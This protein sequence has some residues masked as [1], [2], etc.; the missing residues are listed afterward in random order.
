MKRV[1][2]LVVFLLTLFGYAFGQGGRV[3]GTVTDQENVP[4]P[5]VNIIVEGSATGTISD[6]DGTYAID[7]NPGDLLVF[8]FVGFETQEIRVGNSSVIDIRLGE[9]ISQLDEVVVTALGFKEQ[10]DRLSSTYSVI[11]G[12]DVV[13]QGEYKIIDGIGGKA[14]GV[15]VSS[16]SGD[17]GA[18]A[19]IQIRGQNTITG[20]NQP[21]IIVDG[22][23]INNDW[24]RGDGSESDAGVTQQSRLNDLNPDDIESF[25]VYKGASA[26]ALYGTRA[27]NGVIVITTKR[28]SE[29]RL[30]ATFSSSISVDDVSVRHPLQTTFGQG[31]GGNYSPTDALSWGDRIADRPGG[32]DG[33][34]TTG[35]YFQSETGNLIYPITAKNSRDVFVD[36]NF[37]QVFQNG[38]TFDNNL[39]LSGGSN[40]GT[41]FLS[42]GRINQN[43]IIKESYYDKTNLTLAA[44]QNLTDRLHADVKVNYI[45]SS[46]N[47]T[48]QSSNTA[49]LYLALLRTPPDFDITDYIGDY[50]SSSGAVTQSRQRSYRRY[51][52]NS[53]NATYNNP[54]WTIYQQTNT[55]DVD[56]FIGSAQLSYEVSQHFN[57]LLRTG[58]DSY[59]DNRIYFFPYYT[60]GADRRYGLLRDEVFVNKE[61]NADLLGNLNLDL[62]DRL[63]SNIVLGFGLNDRN[64]KRNFSQADN[65]I[66]NF[67][68][69]L[70][71]IEVS[72]KENIT[73][74]VGR[75]LRRNIR[76]YGTASFDY[77]NQV[78]LTLGGAFEKHSTLADPF[79]YPS[80]ELGWNFTSSFNKP[81]WFNFGKL[82]LS[83]GQVGNVPLPHRAQT[84]YEVGSFSTFSDNITLE[85]FGGGYQLDERVGNS[86]LQPEIKTE[87]EAGV[88][89]RFFR[90]RISL[91]ATY[92]TNEIE[93]AL[94]DMA[95]VPSL[96]FS[97]I[98]GNGATIENN[99]LE[100]DLRYDFLRMGDW[101]AGILANFSRNRNLVTHVEGGGVINFAPGS[102][103]QSVAIEGH[104][105]GVF[106]T[107]AAAR[108][109]DGSLLLDDN[110]FPQVDLTG[111][112]VVGDPNPD[113]RG[114][115]GF[116]LSWKK[117]AVSALF[118]TSQGNDFAERTRFILGYFGTHSDVENEVT[119]TQ[120]LVNYAGDVVPAGTTVRGNIRD[121]G[122]GDVL[123]DE[124][125]Y[126][127]IQGFGDGVLNE[128]A[129]SD[130]SWTRL[131][132]V[133]LSFT[134]DSERFQQ[135]TGLASIEFTASGR[136]LK[137]WTDII[138]ADPDVN[139]FGVG[140]AQ[141]LDYFT[142]PGAKSFLFG[143]KVNY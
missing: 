45:N 79:F 90:N 23:P 137:I 48:Q 129:V 68:G 112:K 132:E 19:N 100:L 10:R 97:E 52:G 82:R 120:D 109:E 53:D 130:G 55:A 99:G 91:S 69:L 73:S 21:L 46:S 105:I 98:Y 86:K 60:A 84:V 115:L 134:I 62:T 116:N 17:P 77:A 80:V 41:F 30:R 103:I 133:S 65:F 31:S 29:G 81:D 36:N 67:R 33:V 131:R 118:E 56:R 42:M 3:T 88:D 22:V 49:G 123:L 12:D 135:A 13:Q 38:T 74:E 114:G 32:A 66:S 124:S 136:N 7:A 141:G 96:G 70:D 140:Q 95:L 119:L 61:Y 47:R 26:G 59:T 8:S 89:L 127:V 6:L 117:V 76:F 5:G 121:F 34:N 58:A 63:F 71:P 128:F 44:T 15:R 43:G 16:M 75:T 122:A 57:L 102:S 24:L 51:L 37:D 138:G 104:P 111:N 27:M 87:Y 142:N 72:K 39:T 83:F 113:W 107:Q 20:D 64:L 4:L 2:L 125:Y 35:Q 40:R 54:L 25:Q 78:F 110:G 9:A 1:P 18:G 92:Y 101:R 106:Y 11:A 14:S 108:N 50:V 143:I 93:N 94:L 139:Q 85:D 126:T 28:G